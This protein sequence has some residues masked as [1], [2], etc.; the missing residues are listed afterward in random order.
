MA[1]ETEPV[2]AINGRKRQADGEL[3][4]NFVKQA[5]ERAKGSGKK[6]KAAQEEVVQQLVL[7]LTKLCLAKAA[8][9]RTVTGA[10]FHT[11]SL[12]KESLIVQNMMA[13][14]QEYHET[15]SKKS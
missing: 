9:L 8:E 14:G 5:K 3:A 15:V 12:P 2:W 7:A 6:G 1:M 13:T 4:E 11:F 10:I